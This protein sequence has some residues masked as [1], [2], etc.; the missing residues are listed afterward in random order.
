MLKFESNT[1]IGKTMSPPEAS[2]CCINPGTPLLVHVDGMG[3][4]I[5]AL[6]IRSLPN[7]GIRILGMLNGTVISSLTGKKTRIQILDCDVNICFEEKKN[8]NS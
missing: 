7:S 2:K 3:D 5:Q 6:F 8:V 1:R 4:W